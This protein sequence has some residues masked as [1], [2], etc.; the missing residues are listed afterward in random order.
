[1]TSLLQGVSDCNWFYVSVMMQS[2]FPMKS[3]LGSVT[4]F[5]FVLF[6]VHGSLL[7]DY[8]YGTEVRRLK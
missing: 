3:I 7:H 8:D 4:Y 2:V 1:M 6:M 5:S